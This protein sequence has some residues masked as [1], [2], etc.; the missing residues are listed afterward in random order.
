MVN[1]YD[2]RCEHRRTPGEIAV[3]APRLSWRLEGSEDPS[4][5][6]IEVRRE[7]GTRV[8]DS[9][10]VDGRD[11]WADYGGAPLASFARYSW[12][13]SVQP[14]GASATSWFGT[15]VL[16]ADEWDAAWIGHDPD[17]EPP[18]E[19]PTDS[20]EPRSRGTASLPAPRLLRRSLEITRPV[21]SAR[22]AC[23]ARGLYELRVNGQR[24]G[25]AE[26]APGWTDYR[27]RVPYQVYD[28]TSLLREGANCV[29]AILADGW[30]SGSLGWTSGRRRRD[31]G[32]IRSSWRSSSSITRTARVPSS[33][34]TRR[35]GA[36][37]AVPLRG[38]A[39]G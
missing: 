30:W 11:V 26:L 29:A 20:R 9:G 25:D 36:H 18:F 17:T 12:Q 28:V 8:W 24:V 31:T 23:S 27:Y 35:G 21:V 19:P 39:D 3:A 4:A 14:S 10:W 6:R 33:G 15:G 16:H 37:R 34:P 22:V 2:L 32:G 5:Y 38:P 7:D 13:V 1:P